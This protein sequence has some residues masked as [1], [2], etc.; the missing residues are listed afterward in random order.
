MTVDQNLDWDG[1]FN[2]R[3]L[4]GLHASDGRQIRRGAIVRA[5]HTNRL[6][7]AGWS[8]LQSHGVRTVIDLR[9]A[10]E[11]EPD[12]A[13]RAAQQTTVE[14]PLEDLTDSTFWQQW[15]SLC[16]TP[17]Y[18]RAF[19][20]R[21]PERIAAVIAAIAE[22]GPGGVLI[23]CGHG[24]DRTGLVTLVLLAL[25]G[26]SPEEIAADYA[27]SADRLRPLFAQMGRD[28]EEIRIQAQLRQA[29]ASARSE[30]LATLEALDAAAYLHA[31]GLRAEHL[32]A[33]H[34][35]LLGEPTSRSAGQR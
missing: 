9:D 29:N 14:L 22:A 11:R 23:H 20:E 18:H 4:G 13:P 15:R 27:L 32:A 26:V 30:I 28:D 12:A 17:L 35:R 3:D 5:D 7:A 31:G 8:A 24:R 6:T 1:C 2:V 10:A 19:L 34:T 21:C 33:I 25:I 16:C